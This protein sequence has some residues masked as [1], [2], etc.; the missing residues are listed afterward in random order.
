VNRATEQ[1]HLG[2]DSK[3]QLKME[4]CGMSLLL[5]AHKAGILSVSMGAEKT[6]DVR[7]TEQRTET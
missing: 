7:V 1:T 6:R 3:S 2:R 4:H 5:R